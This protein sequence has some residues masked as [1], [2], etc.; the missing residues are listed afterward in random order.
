M[1][2]KGS[3][4]RVVPR[5]LVVDDQAHMRAAI[6]IALRAN[7]FGVVCVQDGASGLR[8][9]EGSNFDLAIVDVYMP[10]IDGVRLIKALR[11]RSPNLPVIAMSG[12]PL[13]DSG[14]TVLDFLPDHPSVSKIVCLKKPF[15][16]ADL[17]EA[18]R[19]AISIAA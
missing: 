14:R 13:P 10:G 8:E 5:V 12:V 3:C 7:G 6:A 11:E 4:V 19:S 15:R 18:I 16:P 2:P 17:V 9:F 1:S